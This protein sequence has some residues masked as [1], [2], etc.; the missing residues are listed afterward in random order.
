MANPEGG[1]TVSGPAPSSQGQRSVDPPR[2]ND[3]S[4]MRNFQGHQRGDVSVLT[5]VTNDSGACR[6]QRLHF[7]N[8]HQARLADYIRS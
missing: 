4:T 1:S 3:A 7:V 8:L 2:R 6:L 5:A